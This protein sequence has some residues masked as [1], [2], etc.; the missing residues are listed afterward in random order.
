[1]TKDQLQRV[2]DDV[3]N[4]PPERQ[5]DLM[6]VVE[7]MKAQD[8]SDLQLSNEQLAELRRRRAKRSPSYVSMAEARRQF[9]G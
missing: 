7:V 4:W 8:H 6:H 1:M 2:L 3:L 5:A 9:D